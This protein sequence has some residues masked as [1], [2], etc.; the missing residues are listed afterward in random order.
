MSLGF[1]HRDVVNTKVGDWSVASELFLKS[2]E[3]LRAAEITI[4]GRGEGWQDAL[5]EIVR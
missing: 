4:K 2:G 1:I 5:A 3:P